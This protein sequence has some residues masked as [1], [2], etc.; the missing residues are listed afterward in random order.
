MKDVLY[1]WETMEAR[2]K[3]FVTVMERVIPLPW[4]PGERL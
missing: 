3:D 2:I 1:D 4:R